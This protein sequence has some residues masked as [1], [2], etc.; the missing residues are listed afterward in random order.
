MKFFTLII[1]RKT[2]ANDLKHRFSLFSFL[3]KKIIKILNR[4]SIINCSYLFSVFLQFWFSF[5]CSLVLCLTYRWKK[6]NFAETV[7]E[8]IT[9]TIITR[10]L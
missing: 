4:K 9:N 6:K 5:Y 10:M 3:Y 1:V 7:V 8:K 2:A